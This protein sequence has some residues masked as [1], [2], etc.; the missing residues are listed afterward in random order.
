MSSITTV[1]RLLHFF[2]GVYQLW[3]TDVLGLCTPSRQNT[4]LCSIIIPVTGFGRK[5]KI[6]FYR[7]WSTRTWANSRK[8]ASN[9]SINEYEIELPLAND[10]LFCGSLLLSWRTPVKKNGSDDA[11][12]VSEVMGYGHWVEH[13]EDS[14]LRLPYQF[15]A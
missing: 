6:A 5:A 13:S 7:T 3:K 10:P 8:K 4:R 2:L 11:I 12:A 1:Y 9:Y 15:E 14:F